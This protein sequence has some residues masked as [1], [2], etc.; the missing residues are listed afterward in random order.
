MTKV[1]KPVSTMT[2]IYISTDHRLLIV[3]LNGYM[4]SRIWKACVMDRHATSSWASTGEVASRVNQI[5]IHS[6]QTFKETIE[7]VSHD[8]F[9]KIAVPDFAM[10]LTARTSRVKLGFAELKVK[11]YSHCDL[12]D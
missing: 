8:I 3:G 4:W 1:T 12:A 5:P 2:Y 6:I 11:I 7:I 10:N 9:I